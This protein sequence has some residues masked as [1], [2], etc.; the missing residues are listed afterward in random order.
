MSAD[1]LKTLTSNNVFYLKKKKKNPL[2]D[3]EVW[4]FLELSSCFLPSSCDSGK[5]V[6]TG[7]TP[8]SVSLVS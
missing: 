4:V 7:C 8:C 6:R 1:E 5:R 3:S 2:G